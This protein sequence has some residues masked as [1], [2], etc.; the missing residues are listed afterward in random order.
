MSY[1]MQ[2]NLWQAPVDRAR[3]DGPFCEEVSLKR[4]YRA[5]SPFRLPC[6]LRECCLPILSPEAG[7]LRAGLCIAQTPKAALNAE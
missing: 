3:A 5:K 4:A 6:R 2:I 7:I 1:S